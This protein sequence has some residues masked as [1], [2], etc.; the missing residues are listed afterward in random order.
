MTTPITDHASSQPHS[1]SSNT[2]S[3][4]FHDRVFRS[5][6]VTSTPEVFRTV[7]FVC[8]ICGYTCSTSK[9]LTKHI[10]RQH[11]SYHCSVCDFYTD[12]S[13]SLSVHLQQSHTASL[14]CSVCG[15]VSATC[16][17]ARQHYFRQHISKGKYRCTIDGCNSSF[18]T[19]SDYI[20]HIERL[21]KVSE[22]HSSS[23]SQSF[24]HQNSS[25]LTDR[26]LVTSSHTSEF[27]RDDR[28]DDSRRYEPFPVPRSL[29]L[30][31]STFQ[32]PSFLGK[33]KLKDNSG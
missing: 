25:Q 18:N 6:A 4:P 32:G 9:T 12:D 19:K 16:K 29:T 14:R 5:G 22:T 26:V 30:S 28:D 3:S 17:A 8:H 15:R 2:L 23:D 10:Q 1:V 20:R 27:G 11:S 21:H 7:L 24:P 13:E 31:D 33:L